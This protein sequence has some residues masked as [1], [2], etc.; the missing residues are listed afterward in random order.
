MKY[1]DFYTQY[2]NCLL[3]CTIAGNAYKT[4]I[5]QI[6]CGRY[7]VYTFVTL[8]LVL[9][10]FRYQHSQNHAI[11]FANCKKTHSHVSIFVFIKRLEEKLIMTEN[12]LEWQ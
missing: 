3:T 10:L 5:N 12:K 7:V 1:M 4:D 8:S 2:H 9:F 11:M 6:Q